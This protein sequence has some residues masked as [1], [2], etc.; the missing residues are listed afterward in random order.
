MTEWIVIVKAKDTPWSKATSYGFDCERDAR[1]F[2]EVAADLGGR[3]RVRRV[4]L[5]PGLDIDL[6]GDDAFDRAEQMEEATP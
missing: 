6:G 5:R 1:R 4:V 2:A 3:C